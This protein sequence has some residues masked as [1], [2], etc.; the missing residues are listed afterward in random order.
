M[1]AKYPLVSYGYKPQGGW[2]ARTVLSGV[3]YGRLPID[4][5]EPGEQPKP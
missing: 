4:F 1:A 3:G 2:Q 5:P